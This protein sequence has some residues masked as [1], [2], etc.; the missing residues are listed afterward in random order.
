MKLTKAMIESSYRVLK[1]T[2]TGKTLKRSIYFSRTNESWATFYIQIDITLVIFWEKIGERLMILEKL[3][4]KGRLLLKL[5]AVEVATSF[6]KIA[7]KSTIQFI[8]SPYQ[9][10]CLVKV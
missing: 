9:K 8:E 10:K 7:I 1:V 2:F 4:N 3:R 6:Q 5:R